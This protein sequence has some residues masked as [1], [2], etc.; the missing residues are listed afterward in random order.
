MKNKAIYYH[1]KCSSI[2]YQKSYPGNSNGR[3]FHV[4]TKTMVQIARGDMGW[5][6]FPASKNVEQDNQ[7]SL[8]MENKP[9]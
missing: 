6:I 4:N 9:F 5:G 7:I 2:W 1:G 3:T 8:A